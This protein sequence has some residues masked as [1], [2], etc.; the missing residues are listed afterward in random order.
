MRDTHYQFVGSFAAGSD[1][2][3][4]K[5]VLPPDSNLQSNVN[6][7]EK[8]SES[9]SSSGI[10]DRNVSNSANIVDNYDVPYTQRRLKSKTAAKRR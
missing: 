5:V 7:D 9:S 6:D 10:S 8:S 2:P 3:I 4:K 1:Q